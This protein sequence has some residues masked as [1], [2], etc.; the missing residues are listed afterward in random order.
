VKSFLATA[1]AFVLLASALVVV[2]PAPA[3][4]ASSC[5][6]SGLANDSRLASFSGSVTN[7]D[8]G[9]VV[10]S[11]SGTKA[12]RTASVLKLLTATAA[13]KVLGPDYRL[14]TKVVAGKK[15]GTI[16]LVGGGD[17]TLSRTAKGRAHP[18]SPISRPR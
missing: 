8:T 13:I 14:T 12:K 16:V 11:R 3:Q 18:S 7:L 6:I 2:A 4:A 5:S 15:K 1:S 9:K 10:F 17:A